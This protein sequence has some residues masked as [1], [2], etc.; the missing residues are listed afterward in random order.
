MSSA[1]NIAS[2][3]G[4]KGHGVFAAPWITSCFSSLSRRVSLLLYGPASRG[5]PAFLPLAAELRDRAW[6]QWESFEGGTGK[7]GILFS[8]QTSSIHP[9]VLP[10]GSPRSRWRL[11]LA[12]CA[13]GG[14]GALS[15]PLGGA[16]GGS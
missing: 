1:L 2:A 8:H 13:G 14:G 15:F 12:S 10:P 7:C 3:R 6:E 5:V 16:E 11:C 4:L 9:P